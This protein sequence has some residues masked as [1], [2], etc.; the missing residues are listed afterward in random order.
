[1]PTKAGIH[2]LLFGRDVDGRDTPGHDAWMSADQIEKL[3]PQ[4]QDAVATGLFTLNEAPIRS[5]T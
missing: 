1:M 4:P 5:S 2:V 3:V